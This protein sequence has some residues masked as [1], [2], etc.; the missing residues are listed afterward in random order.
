MD[1]YVHT[2][3]EEKFREMNRVSEMLKVI[4]MVH[5]MVNL[6]MWVYRNIGF[7]RLSEI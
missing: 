6:Q 3:E 4:K 1:L 7:I 2:T 5:K